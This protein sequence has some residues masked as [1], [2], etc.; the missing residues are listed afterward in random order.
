LTRKVVQHLRNYGQKFIK[1]IPFQAVWDTF[2]SAPKAHIFVEESNKAAVIYAYNAETRQYI[3]GLLDITQ[4]KNLELFHK[5]HS[6]VRREA[7]VVR[8]GKV[9]GRF[10]KEQNRHCFPIFPRWNPKTTQHQFNLEG[11]DYY[12]D[13][14]DVNLRYLEVP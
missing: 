12:L 9:V 6:V 13:C 4:K 2:W 5:E 10:I 8:K 7:L 1:E 14:K 3:G 11:W